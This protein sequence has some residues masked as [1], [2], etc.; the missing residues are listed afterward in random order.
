[1]I[2]PGQQLVTVFGGGGFIGRYVCEMLLKSAVRV[3]VAARD[4][5]RAH[6][7]QPLGQVGQLG[8][9]R[10]D[11]TDA[12]SVAR[13]V[14]GSSAV[15]NLC[16]VLKG[17]FQAVHVTGAGNVAQAARDAGAEALVQISAIGADSGAEANY[18]RTKGEGEAAIRAAFPDATIIRPSLVFGPEDQ[19]TNRLAGLARLPFLPVIASQ[20][21]FQP[22]YVRDLA[23]AIAQA[24][25]DPEQYGA[26]T[27]DVGGP[28]AMSMRELH[29]AVL[30]ATGQQPELIDMPDFLSSMLSKFGWLPFAPL[31]RDQWL[32]LQRDNVP[33][34]GAPGLEAFG[35]KPTPLGAVAHEWLGRFNKGGRFAGRRTNL[36]A[37]S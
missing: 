19:I 33:A 34:D 26:R 12:Q 30:E 18:G 8:F 20:R 1:M 35:I 13:A 16:G 21:R 9:V 17:N 10:A 5:R 22:V 32:M 37:T 24:A 36:T 7:I 6:F 11:V 29:Q 23:Q 27:Y 3:R 31:T 25:L 15:I 28:H 14:E 4:P 2:E